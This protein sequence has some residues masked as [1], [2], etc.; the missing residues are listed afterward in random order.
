MRSDG[1][2]ISC[3]FDDWKIYRIQFA[4]F[5]APEGGCPNYKISPTCHTVDMSLLNP[6]LGKTSCDVPAMA[7][8]CPGVSMIGWKI[9]AVCQGPPHKYEPIVVEC[10]TGASTAGGKVTECR[11]SGSVLVLKTEHEF[12]PSPTADPCKA[13]DDRLT[14]VSIHNDLSNRRVHEAISWTG[15][16]QCWIGLTYMDRIGWY[17]RD[18]SPFDYTNWNSGEPNSNAGEPNGA[19]YPSS[20]RWNDQGGGGLAC[21]VCAPFPQ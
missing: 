16:W 12:N 15:A 7:I 13:V 4:S 8:N 20:G 6:C 19:I 17:W 14:L 5:G 11:R 9:Q 18:E 2:R 3:P 21:F 10:S 1:A